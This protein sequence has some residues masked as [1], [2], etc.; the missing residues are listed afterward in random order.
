MVTIGMRL[1]ISVKNYS[2]FA[3][4]KIE[5]RFTFVAYFYA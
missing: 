1:R 4:E 3:L 2:L 5:V